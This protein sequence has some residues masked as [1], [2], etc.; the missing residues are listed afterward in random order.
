[1][2]KEKIATLLIDLLTENEDRVYENRFNIDLITERL[3]SVTTHIRQ[4]HELKNYTT[5][6]FGASTGAASALNAAARLDDTIHAVV[7]RGG[8]PDL[9]KSLPRVKAPSLFIVGSLDEQV[10]ELNRM[11]FA[12]LHCEKKMEII[13]GASHLFEEPG[14]LDEVAAMATQWFKKYLFHHTPGLTINRN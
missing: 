7:S 3:V 6:Y 2:N 11:A 13:E 12:L 1:L 9:C 8:R 10:I 4:L 14:K 5:G